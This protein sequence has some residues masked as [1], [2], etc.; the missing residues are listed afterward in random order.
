MLV[1]SGERN[2]KPCVRKISTH[3]LFAEIN[4]SVNAGDE[5]LS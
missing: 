4:G 1:I 2:Q 3:L 5:E